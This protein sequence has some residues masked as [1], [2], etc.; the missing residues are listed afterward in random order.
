[1][2][3]GSTR[4]VIKDTGLE[5]ASRQ[6]KIP[7]G[8]RGHPHAVRLRMQNCCPSS[9]DVE[10]LTQFLA[11]YRIKISPLIELQLY[12]NSEYRDSVLNDNLCKSRGLLVGN[13]IG[14]MPLSEVV[15]DN[16]DVS[17]AI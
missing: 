2:H 11:N 3:R 6:A 14:F 1:M 9:V 8:Y 17:V 13:R 10:Y 4:L 15:Y 5:L 16:Q 12:R 7:L